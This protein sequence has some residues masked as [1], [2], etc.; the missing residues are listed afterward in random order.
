MGLDYV[1]DANDIFAFNKEVKVQNPNKTK[2]TAFFH[3]ANM[4]HRSFLK[5]KYWLFSRVWDSSSVSHH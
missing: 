5:S 1:N 4:L 2:K 3:L